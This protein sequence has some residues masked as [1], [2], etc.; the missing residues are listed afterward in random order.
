M[1]YSNFCPEN[2]Y[3]KNQFDNAT[4]GSHTKFSFSFFFWSIPNEDFTFMLGSLNHIKNIQL[5]VANEKWDKE[6][7]NENV[8]NP[9]F[10]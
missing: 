1:Q 9:S 2:E 6:E 3:R 5:T 4:E 10:V 8:M 7:A